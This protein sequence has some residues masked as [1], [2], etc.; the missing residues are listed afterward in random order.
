MNSDF[1]QKI[2]NIL[3]YSKEEAVRL[4]NDYIGTEHLFLGILR[5]GEGIA[6]EALNR[7][8]ADLPTLKVNIEEKIRRPEGSAHDV[9]N[10]PLMKSA[11]H[12]LT[13]VY[14]EARAMKSDTIDS[15]HLLLSILRDESSIVTTM[16]NEQDINYQNIKSIITSPAEETHKTQAPQNMFDDDDDNEDEDDTF[17][18]HH[19]RRSKGDN[20]PKSNS[21]TPVLDNFGIDLTKAAE[22]N[23]LDPIVGRETEI[24]RLAQILSRRK[25]NNPVLIG[26]PGVGKSAIAEGMAIRIIQK[27]VSRILFG[28]R[29]IA[30]DLASIVAGTKYRGQFEERMK[31]ILNELQHNPNIILFIDEIH[32]IVGAGG[33]S[34]SLDA[35]NML[36]PAL[37]RGEIQCIGATTLDEY[38]Q[39]IEKDGAL[40]RRFQKVIVEPTSAEETREILN[41][42]KARYEEHHNVTY[43]DEALDACVKLTTRYIS[44]RHLPDKAIDALD[45]AGSRVHISNIHVPKKITDLEKSIDEIRARKIEA[46][47][48][49]KFEEA[50][51]YRDSENKTIEQLENEKQKWETDLIKH[52]ET[53]TADNVAEV[54]AFLFNALRRQ[55]AA[56]C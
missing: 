11:E 46:V 47:K 31:A 55:K 44:D 22:E 19:G 56:D 9:E 49:Q 32:T 17:E 38:R 23:R 27:R 35:A 4:N 51:N 42:I 12:V 15:G 54:V 29:I 7:A 53:V 16:L 39:Y 30:L 13:I 6:I 20:I 2:N 37:A 3:I 41:N 26:E 25:K 8:G 43:S 48:Q 5:D 36:K 24:E 28:K 50:A 14:L 45:E 33:A 10:I 52:R 40:E 1:S 34:G 21:D 18:K